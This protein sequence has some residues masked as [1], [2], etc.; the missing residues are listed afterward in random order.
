MDQTVSTV[1]DEDVC[2]GCGMC[3]KVCPVGTI[4]MK[5]GRAA[6]TGKWSL[7]CGHC[8]AVCPVDAVRVM[9]L[10]KEQSAFGTFD[11]DHRWL[12][13][14]EYDT[15][16]L[17]RLMSSRRSCRNFK[18][19]PVDRPLLEDLVKIGVTAP[20]GTNSQRWSFTILPTRHA[21][22]GLAEKV[23]GFYLRLNRL[24]EKSWLRFLLRMVGKRD[25]EDYYHTYYEYVEEGLM[26]WKQ[27]GRDRLF[28][29][30]HA[31]IVLGSKPGA[32]LP[33]ED[34]LLAAQN[35]LLAAH[36]MGLGTC[37]IGMA[38]EAMKRDRSIARFLG[39]PDKEQ[40]FAIIAL[41]LPDEEYQSTAGR[42][43]VVP[44]YFEG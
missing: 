42:K 29:G 41:G 3:V 13:H 7:N 40:T 15:V 28:H 34:A 39:I 27:K 33:K 4:S 12:P 19:E 9:S 14:G 22:I 32:T 26:E 36:A 18:D 1:I 43:L 37:L 2:I 17:V 11:A 30:A 8:E 21:V 24:A 31:A 25:L 16:Q 23:G 10:D 20:S 44:R 5:E 38:V 6:V 35:M